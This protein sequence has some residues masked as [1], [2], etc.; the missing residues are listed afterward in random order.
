MYRKECNR[1]WELP[2]EPGVRVLCVRNNL[3][4]IGQKV[5]EQ[6]RRQE[7]RRRDGVGISRTI[8]KRGL[9][10]VHWV[11]DGVLY[12]PMEREWEP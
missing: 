8:M 2:R 9:K 7:L 1:H 11:P 10:A 12:W 5:I 4:D 6:K 3:R